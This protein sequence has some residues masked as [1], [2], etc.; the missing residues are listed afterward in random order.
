[1]ES[2]FSS[3]DKAY[4][5][6]LISQP[7]WE[8]IKF[9]MTQFELPACSIDLSQLPTVP[10]DRRLGHQAEFVFL[11]LL[12]ACY[13]YEVLAHSIQLIHKK[14]TLGELD[15]IIQNV[16]TKEV[17]HI[18]LTYKFYIV[19]KAIAIP[20]DQIIGPNRKDTF[21]FKLNKT[22]DK[23]MPLLYSDPSIRI[24]DNME[25]DV[26]NIRQMVAFYAH[27]FVPYDDRTFQID[28]LNEDCVVGYWVTQDQ[29][30]TDEFKSCVYYKPSKSEW[31]HIPHNNKPWMS[32]EEIIELVSVSLSENR[33]VMLW[34]NNENDRGIERFFILG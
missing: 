4:E 25:L 3:I 28:N 21:A 32:F 31:L 33:A 26:T 20:L 2:K 14:Q 24:L 13:E 9:G 1:M 12:N 6:F 23:Q 17:L 15:Y 10:T 29:V 7:F 19:D 5:G 16:K 22:R 30:Q 18:E 34:K 11:Q 27:I 8:G